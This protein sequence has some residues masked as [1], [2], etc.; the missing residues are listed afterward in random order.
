MG[1]LF[2]FSR[3]RCRSRSPVNKKRCQGQRWHRGYHWHFFRDDE[4]YKSMDGWT[5]GA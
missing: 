3:P 2:R 5:H 1:R 4:G